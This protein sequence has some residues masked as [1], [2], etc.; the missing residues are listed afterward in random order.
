MEQIDLFKIS[1]VE[2]V[3]RNKVKARYRPKVTSSKEAYRLFRQ[4]WDDCKINLLEQ[5]KILLMDRGNRCLGI[6]DISQGGVTGTVVDPKIVFATAL[7]ARACA[8]ILGHNHPSESLQPSQADI[9][10]TKRLVQAGQCLDL[11]VLDHL[12]VTHDEYY[13]MA[14][15]GLLPS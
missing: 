15:E 14:D 6:A 8:I 1:E 10:L 3:Y 11:H 4:N 5:F 12:I 9:Q 2:L 13:S 7:K